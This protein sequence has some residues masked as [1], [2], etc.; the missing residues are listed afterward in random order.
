MVEGM[1]LTPII[2]KKT[3]FYRHRCRVTIKQPKQRYYTKINV[4]QPDYPYS[5]ISYLG[6][7]EL[8][9]KCSTIDQAKA[10]L[11]KILQIT[12]LGRFQGEGMGQIKWLRGTIIPKDPP[13]PPRP[14]KLKIR[15]GLPWNLP[16]K[17]QKLIQYALLHD[18][19]HTS[20]HQSKI[21]VEP[22]LD[23]IVLVNCLKQ[24]HVKTTNPLI[25]V[26]QH[27]DQLA[28]MITRNTRAPVPT[29]YNWNARKYVRK[30]DFKRLAHEIKEVSP[31]VWKLYHYIYT[32]NELHAI[33]ESLLYGHTA[34]RTHLLVISNL[35]INDFLN[36]KLS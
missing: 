23:D 6:I 32:S 24:H 30:I 16:P 8:R 10:K 17:I 25:Q 18:F 5:F 12:A 21:Y 2:T 31:N 7:V 29:R 19:F 33:T 34:L 14:R 11:K 9:Y 20:H 26:F 1:L 3:S 27:Y 35:I 22:P 4:S 15:K 13:F 36:G 28:S